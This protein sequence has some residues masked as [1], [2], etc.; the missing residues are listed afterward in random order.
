MDP[1]KIPAKGEIPRPPYPAAA[2]NPPMASPPPA[3]RPV[4]T[5]AY[6]GHEY[7]EGT[8]AFQHEQLTMHIRICDQH[9]MRKAEERIRELEARLAARSA[10][11][12]RPIATAPKTSVSIIV[13]CPENRCQFMVSWH[14]EDG[15]LIFGPGRMK[16][17]CVPTHWRPCAPSP[18]LEFKTPEA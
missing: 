18:I 6:C 9:P 8:P 12:W 3:P 11:G 17:D 15:W 1:K 10:V 5:C 4:I 7:P 16:L 14:R 2:Y 13:W